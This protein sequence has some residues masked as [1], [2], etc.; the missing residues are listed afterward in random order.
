[1]IGLLNT[2][3]V[4]F[5]P[6]PI[7][8][9]ELVFVTDDFALAAYAAYPVRE[10]DAERKVFRTSDRHAAD[11][12][13]VMTGDSQNPHI[14]YRGGYY[15]QGQPAHDDR[16]RT[17]NRTAT[18]GKPMRP[19]TTTF[20]PTFSGCLAWAVVI[21]VLIFIVSSCNEQRRLDAA[22]DAPYVPQAA[23]SS[24]I[25]VAT[26][27]EAA[28]RADRPDP[29]ITG[30]WVGSWGENDQRLILELN[31]RTLAFVGYWYYENRNG[32]QMS[33]YM[34]SVTAGYR[35]GQDVRFSL[36][37]DSKTVRTWSGALSDDTRTLAGAFDDGTSMTFERQ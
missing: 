28:S 20:R 12:V 27:D 15:N 36:D 11:A 24:S 10:I 35:K 16:P 19:P 9:D 6:T 7:E 8:A 32:K 34:D 31:A 33:E 3:K 26:P 5:T 22:R 37:L 18:S 2:V 30:R 17:E 4:Y 13:I 14:E 23:S 21:P 1:M 29:A 25:P